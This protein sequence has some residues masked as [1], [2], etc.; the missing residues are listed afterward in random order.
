MDVGLIAEAFCRYVFD[1]VYPYMAKEIRWNTVGKDELL[2][3]E[4]VIARYVEAVKFPETI[5]PTI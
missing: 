2:S 5:S 3:R 1:V 4:A